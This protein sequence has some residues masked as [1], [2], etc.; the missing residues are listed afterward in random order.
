[1]NAY[2]DKIPEEEHREAYC[3]FASGG[4]GGGVGDTNRVDAVCVD[5][6][7]RVWDPVHGRCGMLPDPALRDTLERIVAALEALSN[8][9]QP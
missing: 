6:L 2:C 8:I 9:A 3:P 1:M 5:K 7:C 4:N